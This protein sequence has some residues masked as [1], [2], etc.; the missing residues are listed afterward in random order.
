[1][2]PNVINVNDER[3]RERFEILLKFST[4]IILQSLKFPFKRFCP[5]AISLNNQEKALPLLTQL[6][7]ALSVCRLTNAFKKEH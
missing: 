5:K 7:N 6:W 4:L 2:S 1:M 3:M